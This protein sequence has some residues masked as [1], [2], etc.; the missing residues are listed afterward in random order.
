MPNDDKLFDSAKQILN[1]NFANVLQASQ[2]SFLASYENA[3]SRYFR[4]VFT[5]TE[6][7]YETIISVEVKTMLPVIVR[8]EKLEAGYVGYR[9][10]DFQNN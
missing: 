2:V 4:I 7:R 8:W 1:T 6:G 9:A 5:T 10:Q 3:N